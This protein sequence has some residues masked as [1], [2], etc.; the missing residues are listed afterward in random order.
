MENLNLNY[1]EVIAKCGHV[2]NKS[3]IPIKFPVPAKN[4]KAAV[5]K[6]ILYRRVK[7]GNNIIISV[8]KISKEEYFELREINRNDEYL[9]CHNK[10]EQALVEGLESRVVR[11][12]KIEEDE[13]YEE[14]RISRIKF[15]QRKQKIIDEYE[16]E[17]LES[18]Y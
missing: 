11:F 13:F 18:A 16:M 2:G 1:Y 5:D 14:N 3:F 15:K 10:Y 4:K 17:E 6:A 12:E 9:K 8:R 7:G